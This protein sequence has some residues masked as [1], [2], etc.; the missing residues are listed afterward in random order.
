MDRRFE[1]RVDDPATCEGLPTSLDPRPPDGASASP[2]ESAI[3]IVG[4]EANAQSFFPPNLPTDRLSELEEFK[5]LAE[6]SD[7]DDPDPDRS[8]TSIG[9]SASRFLRPASMVVPGGT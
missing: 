8:C 6:H 9:L 4:R 5:T 3:G 7:K 1:C 2:G